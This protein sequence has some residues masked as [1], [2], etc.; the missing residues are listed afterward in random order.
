MQWDSH[1]TTVNKIKIT[2]MRIFMVTAVIVA[3]FFVVSWGVSKLVPDKV[4]FR[5]SIKTEKGSLPDGSYDVRV[6]SFNALNSSDLLYQMD[7]KSIQVK[8]GQYEL[9]YNLNKEFAS[10]P[11]VVEICIDSGDGF[12]DKDGNVCADGSSDSIYDYALCPYYMRSRADGSFAWLINRKVYTERNMIKCPNLEKGTTASSESIIEK[13]N[14]A[15][16]NV[17][18]ISAGNKNQVVNNITNI[19]QVDDPQTLVIEG[20]VLYISGGNSVV[21]P[22]SGYGDTVDNDT[23]YSAGS[24]LVLNSTTFS[25][26][27]GSTNGQ[28]EVWDGSNWTDLS[29]GTNGQVLTIVGGT[30][31]WQSGG[32]ETD[33]VIGNEITNVDG[34]T[35]LAR[36]GT[37]T[38]GDPFIVALT[39]T[40]V[41]AGTYNNV[42]VNAYGRVTSASNIAYLTSE[43]DGIVGNELTNLTAGDGKGILTRSGTGTGGDP[44]TLSVATCG[45]NQIFKSN[46]SSWACS[47]DVDTDTTYSAGNGLSLS[48]TTFSVNS[49]TCAGTDK[50]QW[51]G[52]AFVCSA[53]V[54]TDTDT[55]DFNVSAQG[56]VGSQN[57]ADGG[58][59]SFSNGTG[60]T[61]TRS[62]SAVTYSLNDTAVTTGTYGTS[63]S[64]AQFTVDQQGRITGASS[65]AID[66]AGNAV[67]SVT[68]GSGLTN[69]GGPGAITINVGAGNGIT[70]NANDITVDTLDSADALS[71]T[72]SNGSGLEV[73]A[74]GIGLL[75][76][77][78]DNQILK[79]N[80]AGDLWGCANDT[81]TDT[82]TTNFNIRANAGASANISSGGTVSFVD[83]T[84]T[85]ASRSGNDI[86]FNLTTT[87]VSANS[88]GS[89][90]QVPVFTVDAYGRISSVT[91]T[92]IN[93][94]AEVDGVV[95][96]EVTNATSNAGLTRS[97]T[98]TGGDPYTLGVLLP[99]ATDALSSTTSTGSGL[100]LTSSGLS[101][102]QGC[103]NNQI[104]KW[105]ETSDV[106]ACSSDVDT[107]TTYSAGNGLSLS[108]TTFSV[109]SP[110]CAGTDKLQWNGSA[111]VCSADVDTDTDTTDFNVSAQGTV[112]SQNIADGGTVSFSNGTGT[113]A[114][115][116][117]SAVTYSLNDTAVTTGTYGTSSS[118]AQFTVDQQGRITG[119]SS[120]AIDFAGNAVTSVTA[121]SGLTN[122]GGPG[123][124]TINVGAGNGITVNA[125]DI[126]VDTL[127][128]ADALSSTTSNGSGLEVLA[129][130]IG[131]LQG[132]SDNQILKWNEAG[133]LWGCAADASGGSMTIGTINSQTKSADGA[134]IS[135]G[136]LYMQTA[137]GTNPGLVST[138]AQ[139]FAGNKTFS[140]ALIA[141]CTNTSTN[142]LCDGGNTRGAGIVL[143]SN[144]NFG[145]TFETNNTTAMTIANNGAI[146]IGATTIDQAITI[147]NGTGAL[148]LG[149]SSDAK[150]INIGTGTGID[151]INIGTGATSADAITFGNTGVATTLTFNSGVSTTTAMSFNLNSLTSGNGLVLSATSVTSGEVFEI[152]GP[153]SRS[154]LRVKNE[155]ADPLDDQ[156]VIIGQGGL[157]S[158]KPDELARDQLYVFGRINYSWNM[159]SQDFLGGA[160]NLTADGTAFNAYYDEVAG[161]G[162]TAPSGVMNQQSLASGSGAGRLTFSGTLGTGPWASLYGTNVNVTERSLN[163]V[164]EARIQASSNTDQRAIAGFTDIALNTAIA[165]DTNN[166]ANEVFFR[167][168]A[169]GTNWEAVTRNASG[170]ENVTGLGTACAGGTACTTAA[171]RTMRIE[172]ENVGA[173]G[174]ARFYIDGTL[175]ATHTTAAV[176]A[177]TTRLGWKIGTTPTTTTYTG[178]VVDID[179]V[180]VWSDD[181]PTDVLGQALSTTI[182]DNSNQEQVDQIELTT[183][184][185]VGNQEEL[186]NLIDGLRD[187][188]NWLKGQGVADAALNGGLV[189]GNTTFA[190]FVTFNSGV[191]FDSTVDFGG[192]VKFIGQAEFDGHVI[193]GTDGAGTLELEAGQTSTRFAFAKPYQKPPVVTVTPLD[194]D[195]GF[196]LTNVDETGFTITISTSQNTQTRFNWIVV[197]RQ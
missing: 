100:E 2:W 172:L 70:V 116:S 91:N 99:S 140:D 97:G 148:S 176:P 194:Y 175:V 105:N 65:V 85:T 166:S 57:I 159:F 29:A 127:D 95:G 56:T 186:A 68:A 163:P 192:D 27:S 16:L 8:D 30:P 35:G 154:I 10:V 19:N 109:N 139:S 13:A 162:G 38:T 112:G 164:F 83:G 6:R 187:D 64:V 93:F 74:S 160:T 184:D 157:A 137:D 40:G 177:N 61:A 103:S 128:S 169:A 58:T 111:F 23:T 179:Y 121:G 39:T 87:G 71:S 131:L 69:G 17:S 54:D 1:P 138:G 86:A 15:G 82:D 20:N 51:N 170:A 59:V 197:G 135:S 145:L 149:N 53:D 113:T 25:R 33:G 147:D 36:T 67:T 89:S 75:Q 5:G 146:T 4:T 34:T 92:S 168:T 188:V 181:P 81:D 66:F 125:N 114:T 130:G 123:A 150:T 80:E 174:T 142:V 46:G 60:T 96:N 167:K 3:L 182:I 22:S 117:G 37:G 107:D 28:I 48:T 63:S 44:Y 153:S 193:F 191:T 24:G 102:I 132:C 126:T 173:N 151:T 62:G 9:G 129:S 158:S 12:K 136:V 18:L 14:E 143:G 88:Y 196:R 45:L 106:W 115:R 122:G 77:C 84:G 42:T 26:E 73:L 43:T 165:A 47:S 11:A 134:V 119:A 118:V 50:L 31:V 180:R 78:S 161:S 101:L 55:T 185:L 90:T 94:P 72:T 152:L 52:S 41:S 21:L 120:V 156:R 76:G 110:T 49:P 133:D 190:D 141:T 144:D 124:I 189:S 195:A 104:L 32:A 155:S 108:T 98:G 183:F 171:M 178:R 7:F 79:W